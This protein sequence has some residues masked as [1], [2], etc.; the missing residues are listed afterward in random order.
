MTDRPMASTFRAGGP[1]LGNGVGD[2]IEDFRRIDFDLR[3]VVV[4]GIGIAGEE[5]D[6]SAI[7]DDAGL[8]GGGTDV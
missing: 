2:G 6:D 7:A 4:G 5:A 3:A 1:R 8:D